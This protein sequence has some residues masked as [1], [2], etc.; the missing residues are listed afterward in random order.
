MVRCFLLSFI[1]AKI[2]VFLL[3]ILAGSTSVLSSER[4][5]I[6]V[7]STPLVEDIKTTSRQFFSVSQYDPGEHRPS[8][9]PQKHAY[10]IG[11]IKAKNHDHFFDQL[12]ANVANIR[13]AGGVTVVLLG[14]ADGF[15]YKIN[16]SIEM[17]QCSEAK[18]YRELSDYLHRLY[19]SG[20][21]LEK[22]VDQVKASPYLAHSTLQLRRACSFVA[23]VPEPSLA[24]SGSKSIYIGAMSDL[25]T[26]NGDEEPEKRGVQIFVLETQ[27]FQ[28]QNSLFKYC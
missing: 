7:L 20:S 1:R 13:E 14:Q 5:P 9:R 19:Y 8:L 11:S 3:V 21:E 27:K 25:D 2:I 26:L 28:I 18:A 17:K 15:G 10:F 12:N 16:S 6:F 22:K 23:N 24:C 4:V